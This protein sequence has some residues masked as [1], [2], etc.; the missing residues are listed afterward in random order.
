MSRSSGGRNRVCF[1]CRIK[2][3]GLISLNKLDNQTTVCSECANELTLI[4]D[5]IE[6]PK[7]QNIKAWKT[8]Q[9][10]ILQKKSLHPQSKHTDSSMLYYSISKNKER[11]DLQSRQITYLNETYNNVIKKLFIALTKKHKSVKDNNDKLWDF[12]ISLKNIIIEIC[13]KNNPDLDISVLEIKEKNYT[14][15]LISF[16]SNYYYM[17]IKRNHK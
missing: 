6:T 4:P 3:A 14:I 12:E 16:V 5:Y 7:K 15:D 9:K 8:L 17:K 10:N 11:Y 2:Y 13:K 1:P